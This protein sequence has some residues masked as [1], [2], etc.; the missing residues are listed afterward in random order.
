MR[1][2]Q[3]AIGSIAGAIAIAGCSGSNQLGV[4]GNGEKRNFTVQKEA[5]QPNFSVNN[6]LE[7]EAE[8]T[9]S[10]TNEKNGEK[11]FDTLSVPA[12]TIRYYTNIFDLKNDYRV[13]VTTPDKSASTRFT[14]SST[15]SL[16]VVISDS[17]LDLSV[18]DA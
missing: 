1:R 9:V 4:G 2:R 13:K 7:T 18:S 11:Y 15:N 12:N 17:G 10:V 6:R 5:S 3:F 14:N 8:P 16:D